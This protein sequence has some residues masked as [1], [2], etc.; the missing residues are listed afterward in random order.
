[1]DHQEHDGGGALQKA[2]CGYQRQEHAAKLIHR[3]I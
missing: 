1:V 3:E 2:C